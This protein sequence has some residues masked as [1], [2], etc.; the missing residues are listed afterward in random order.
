MES[1]KGVVTE[2]N[3]EG[4]T[5]FG[6]GDDTVG[7]PYRAQISQFELILL[8]KLDKQFPVEQFE[9]TVYQSTIPCPLLLMLACRRET[10]TP[11]VVRHVHELHR[12]IH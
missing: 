6:R 1:W 11:E 3:L 7:N 2:A 12:L 9:A 5:V 4:R 10:G 8:L